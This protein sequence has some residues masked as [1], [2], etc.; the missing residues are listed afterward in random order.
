[1]AADGAG[2]THVILSPEWDSTHPKKPQGPH[3]H[4]PRAAHPMAEGWVSERGPLGTAALC[5]SSAL[6]PRAAA[7]TLGLRATPCTHASRPPPARRRLSRWPPW[8]VW[9]SW[10]PLCR[11]ESGCLSDPAKC[12]LTCHLT[13]RHA[14]CFL[15]EPSLVHRV[16]RVQPPAVSADLRG[17]NLR[18]EA[19]KAVAVQTGRAPEPLVG[20]PVQAPGPPLGFSCSGPGGG[21]Q[22]PHDVGA[23]DPQ[24]TPRGALA[25][26]LRSGKA[27]LCGVFRNIP[28]MP[29]LPLVWVV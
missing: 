17:W 20:A 1:M 26:Q 7:P 6:Y 29:S 11:A 2:G 19:A 5:T 23:A 9:T 3:R 15:Q 4:P 8:Q 27:R 24:G 10:S 21:G 12:H 14:P 16:L 13:G 28:P 18:P 25:Q 22:P